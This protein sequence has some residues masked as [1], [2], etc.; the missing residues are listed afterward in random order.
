MEML[1]NKLKNLEQELA[2]LEAEKNSEIEKLNAEFSVNLEN[3]QTNLSKKFELDLESKLK[4]L[5]YELDLKLKQEKIDLENSLNTKFADEK[6]GIKFDHEKQIN[7][8]K[9]E[10]MQKLEG[11]EAEIENLS[12]EYQTEKQ[13]LEEKA[14][15]LAAEIFKDFLILFEGLIT[16]SMLK[17]LSGHKTQF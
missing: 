8:V 13:S 5:R 6:Q 3:E 10:F 9:K 17:S 14:K 7:A 15:Q 1:E 12:S 2:S 11:K 4:Q 16:G